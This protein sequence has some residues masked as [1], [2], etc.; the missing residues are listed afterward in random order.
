M[1]DI[2]VLKF[3]GTSV[4]N[5]QRLRHVA[6]IV[7]EK[8]RAQK[9]IVVVSAMG[10]TTDRLLHLAKQCCDEPVPEEL[11]VLLSTGEQV[12]IALLS[13]LLKDLG[14]KAKSFTGAQIGIKTDDNHSNAD[15]LD[16]SSD[17]ILRALADLDVLVVA[18]FQGVTAGGAITTLGRGGSD[19][20][21]VAIA[22]AVN[23]ASCDIFT[24]VDGIYNLDPNKHHGA[25][26]YSHIS[27]D[28]CLELA[29]NGAQV[30][31]PRA[32]RAARQHRLPV[33]VRSTFCLNDPGTLIRSA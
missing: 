26:R 24:D 29:D 4:K 30:I 16:I 6:S 23:A 18:G 15:I 5:V 31:H 17:F 21:A 32:V 1:S 33:R 8:A 11:D 19:T 27:F 20:T 10:D 2:A 25:V 7:E 28:D 13:I 9:V 14:L 3:G 12:T 22:A